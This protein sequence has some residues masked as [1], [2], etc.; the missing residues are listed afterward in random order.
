MLPSKLPQLKD[1]LNSLVDR[2]KKER[3]P[4]ALKKVVD[5]IKKLV[6]KTKK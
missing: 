4:R 2:P 6:V 1:K 5:K 3:K